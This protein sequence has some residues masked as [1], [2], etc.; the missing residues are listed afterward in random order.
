MNSMLA[1]SVDGSVDV[2][3]CSGLEQMMLNSMGK[4]GRK[5]RFPFPPNDEF[6]LTEPTKNREKA[7][8]FL[9]S[10]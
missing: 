6:I 7:E 2:H 8:K 4:F 1:K 9:E 10:A 3:F 5:I